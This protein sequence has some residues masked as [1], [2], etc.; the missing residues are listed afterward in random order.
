MVYTLEARDNV[1]LPV[2]VKTFNLSDEQC[3]R[4]IQ[5]EFAELRRKLLLK[6]ID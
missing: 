5:D 1:L 4:I 3:S 2:I 6:S